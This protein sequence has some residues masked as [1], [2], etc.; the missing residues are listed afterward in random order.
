MLPLATPFFCRQQG[1]L[2]SKNAVDGSNRTL[3]TGATFYALNTHTQQDY[4]MRSCA[5]L[6]VALAVSPAT[7]RRLL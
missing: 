4:H 3:H 1:V 6:F 2:T 5:L 7:V